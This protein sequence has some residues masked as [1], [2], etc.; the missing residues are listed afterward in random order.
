MTGACQ[1]TSEGGRLECHPL[2]QPLTRREMD[3]C[4]ATTGTPA[5]C[6]T[7]PGRAPTSRVTG[8]TGIS[9]ASPAFPSITARRPACCRLGRCAKWVPRPPALMGESDR[10]LDRQP[11]APARPT[12]NVGVRCHL[13]GVRVT[14]ADIDRTPGR[15]PP[16]AA[17]RGRRGVAGSARLRRTGRGRRRAPPRRAGRQRVDEAGQV[18]AAVPGLASAT[19]AGLARKFTDAQWHAVETGL[20]DVAGSGVRRTS[21]N[22]WAFRCRRSTSGAPVAMVRP[23]AG[24]A[25][26]CGFCPTTSG[27]G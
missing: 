19:A 22:I 3:A 23:V 27:R 10:R 9:P 20:A 12:H 24:W 2:G 15:E 26:T 13:N 1:Q 6:R 18:L 11:G 14:E 7:H 5:G 8:R 16:G 4:N 17:G 21:P 25:S